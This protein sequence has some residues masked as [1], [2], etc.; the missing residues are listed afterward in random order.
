MQAQVASPLIAVHYED[1]RSAIILKDP[2]EAGLQSLDLKV[3]GWAARSGEEQG[4][5]VKPR[6]A[7]HQQ[8]IRAGIRGELHDLG[9]Q[10]AHVAPLPPVVL[11]THERVDRK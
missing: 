5:F 6:P 9:K 2:R 8:S 3:D 10:L 1:L 11:L 7:D 4:G